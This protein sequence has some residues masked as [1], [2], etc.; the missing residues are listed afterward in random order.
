MDIYRD[1]VRRQHATANRHDDFTRCDVLH[2]QR[3][4]DGVLK[5]KPATVQELAQAVVRNMRSTAAPERVV[6]TNH[7]STI[8]RIR[9]TICELTQGRAPTNRPDM[10]WRLSI[11]KDGQTEFLG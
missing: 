1:S 8:H 5:M 7:E 2:T 9:R 11:C 6:R 4:C 10:T 3:K